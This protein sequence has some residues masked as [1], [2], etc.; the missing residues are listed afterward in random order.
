MY[1]APTLTEELSQALLALG[2]CA[3]EVAQTLVDKGIELECDSTVHAWRSRNCP[4]AR[5]INQQFP[6]GSGS[7]GQSTCSTIHL[8]Y[9]GAAVPTPPHVKEFIKEF[10]RFALVEKITPTPDMFSEER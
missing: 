9:D 7:A 4:I 3:R 1:G 10:D 5:Y 8:T 2:N 6:E